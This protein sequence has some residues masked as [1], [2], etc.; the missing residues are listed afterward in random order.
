MAQ[1]EAERHPT[2]LRLMA[3]SAAALLLGGCS[4]LPNALNP[5]EWYRDATGASSHDD[6]TG[7]ARNTQNLEAGGKQPYPNLGSVPKP[8]DTALS[9]AE[10][11]KLQKGLVAD[12]ANARYSDEELRQ[13]RTVPPLPGEPAATAT[14]AAAASGAAADAPAGSAPAS[15]EGSP[16][17]P[18]GAPQRAP[19]ARGSAT[20]PQESPLVT[21]QVRGTPTGEAAHAAPP[22]PPGVAQGT[23]PASGRPG[24][25]RQTALVLPPAAPTTAPSQPAAM[26]APS[27]GRRANVVLQAAEIMFSGGSTSLSEQDNRNLAEVAKLT[28]N[29]GAHLRVISYM[30][31]A[32]GGDAAERELHAFGGAVD[33]ANAV[34]QALIKL[35]VAANRI[36]VQAAPELVSTG[37]D[38]ARVE[39]FLEY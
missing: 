14:T 18:G 36:T 21:P 27:T 19:P 9:A 12:R 29:A 38:A 11:E 16:A 24:P 32:S 22:A 4:W 13:G 34:A 20:A 17:A 2:W 30:R 31:S 1:R 15:G 37:S 8:P 23:Q 7:S 10:R 35:G 6:E 25:G 39:V 33:R 28:Q 26:R 5:I 3:L